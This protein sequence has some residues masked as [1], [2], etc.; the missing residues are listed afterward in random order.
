M[1]AE[2]A[3]LFL[4]GHA[5]AL[6]LVDDEQPEI[7]EGH[8]FREQAVR[9]D[10][11]I[12]FAL[13]ELFERGFLL[14]FGAKARQHVDVDRVG[15][16]ALAKRLVMLS[17]EDGGRH[18]EGDLLAVL[19]GLEGGTDGD[20]GFPEADVAADEPVHRGGRFHVRLDGLGGSGL[21]G[22]V[23]ILEGGFEFALPHRVR[24][25]GE[26]CRG[27][28]LR[29]EFDEVAGDVLD[30]LFRAR[31][32][33]FPLPGAEL[34]QTRLMAL[35]AGVLV[36]LVERVHVDVQHVL[37]LIDQPDGLLLFAAHSDVL[38]A[39][40][41][42]DAVVDVDHEV[43]GG[44]VLKLPK[45]E[46]A[47]APF[48]FSG[49]RTVVAVEDL[50]VGID[51]EAECG[52]LEALVE[53]G[54]REANAVGVPV[55]FEELA[56]ASFLAPAVAQDERV[57][58][59]SGVLG[60]SPVEHAEI[61]VEGRLGVCLE[62]MHVSVGG[63]GEPAEAQPGMRE[64]GTFQRGAVEEAG[65][66][67]RVGGARLGREVRKGIARLLEQ[68]LHGSAYGGFIEADEEGAGR[69]EVEEGTAL[70][71]RGRIPFEVGHEACG[72]AAADRALGAY[73]ELADR[74]DLIS[75]ELDAH[76]VIAR[77][78]E[79][80]EDAAAQGHLARLFDEL[81]AL[82]AVIGEAGDEAR[83]VERLPDGEGDGLPLEGVW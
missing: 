82:E 50:V 52:D 34:R 17:G 2:L 5:E 78:G 53:R 76:G 80:V 22:R 57:H 74:V 9:P 25:E 12:H 37:V 40:E 32:C 43:A 55:V 31:L 15:G 71:G 56:E 38:H 51:G 73:F 1:H 26:A 30:P 60:E 13:F 18:E 36:Q 54:D 42:P 83:G 39:R 21:V 10:D 44:E 62:R 46:A 35:L 66:G 20:F 29:I 65:V 81:D 28:S 8:V 33:P 68:G 16:E 4:D 75:E 47:E 61:A 19:S 69:Q 6:L 45:A 70:G 24:G 23:L 63:E 27:L 14:C 64:E 79:D 59:G 67:G 72:G 77:E 41:L 11:D 58:A 48:L 49:R 3:Q 7:L